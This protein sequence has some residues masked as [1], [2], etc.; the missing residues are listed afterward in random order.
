MS[1]HCLNDLVSGVL[2]WQLKQTKTSSSDLDTETS[3]LLKCHE[4][5]KHGSDHLQRLLPSD[6][7]LSWL[8]RTLS[9]REHMCMLPSGEVPWATLVPKVPINLH[10]SHITCCPSGI[11]PRKQGG[12]SGVVRSYPLMHKLSSCCI[13]KS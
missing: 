9:R 12:E 3:W 2:L 7:R 11:T 5:V 6:T 4:V 13:I 10:F 1:A 8:T